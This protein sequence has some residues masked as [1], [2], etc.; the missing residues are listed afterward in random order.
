MT[1]H[2]IQFL[3]FCLISSIVLLSVAVVLSFWRL[4]KGPHLPDHIIALD[5]ISTLCLCIIGVFIVMSKH[6]VY[7][8]IMITLALVSF[9]SMIA[10]SKFIEQYK[11]RRGK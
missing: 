10:F 5:S 11:E 7:L 4:I 1:N 9:L 2:S 8:D 6:P 3:S